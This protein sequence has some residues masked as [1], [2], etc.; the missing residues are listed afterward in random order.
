MKMKYRMPRIGTKVNIQSMAKEMTMTIIATTISIVLTFGS[1]SLLE[2]KQKEKNRRQTVMMVIHDIEI[3]IGQLKDYKEAEELYIKCCYELQN[4]IDEIDKVSLDTLQA[5]YDYLI[6]RDADMEFDSSKEKLFHENQS[7]WNDLDDNMQI[8]DQVQEYYIGRRSHLETMNKAVFWE[9]PISL[10][11]NKELLHKGSVEGYPINIRQVMKEKMSDSKV[12]F[13]LQYS[14]TRQRFCEM[15]ADY[16]KKIAD[17]LKFMIGVTDE[18]LA[19]YI[20]THEQLGRIATKQDIIGEWVRLDSMSGYA[21]YKFFVDGTYSDRSQW[22]IKNSFYTGDILNN[23][24]TGGTW[25]FIGDTLVQTPDPTSY[26]Y[27]VDASKIQYNERTQMSTS[28]GFDFER[29]LQLGMIRD[30]VNSFINDL[31]KQHKEY[32]DWFKQGH[33]SRCILRIDD[34]GDKIEVTRFDDDNT[35]PTVYYVKRK[36]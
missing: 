19:A 9:H 21:R 20:S 11:E 10:E 26:M 25:E 28:S 29:L 24:R 34:S 36:H 5:L 2:K 13:Y 1:S 33:Q 12:L 8:I 3:N 17:R 32:N 22:K 7:L 30:S 4:R 6:A 16:W 18:E 35:S 14:P 15:V 23:S 31:N 27:N